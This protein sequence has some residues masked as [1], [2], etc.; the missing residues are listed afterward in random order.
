MVDENNRDSQIAGVHLT[1]PDR[2]LYPRQGITKRELALYYQGI[3]DWILPHLQGR[4][5][6]LV[7]CPEGQEKECFYQ[8]H[9]SGSIHESVRRVELREEKGMATYLMADSLSG[10]IALVQMGV[11]ELHTWGSRTDKLE[12]P[13]RLVFDLDPGPGIPWTAVVEAAHAM[14]DRLGALGLN[15]LVKTTG[16]KGLH[17]VAPLTRRHDWDDIKG[18]SKAI[19]ES[20]VQEA[21]KRYTATM[22]KAKRKGKIFID[23]LRNQRGA[24]TVAAYSSRAAPDA[25]ISAPIGWDELDAS[26]G[27]SQYNI[28]NLPRRLATLRRD[29]WQ[30][31]EAAR[32][33]ILAKTKKELARML[34][35]LAT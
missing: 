20:F 29:P 13:D 6:T 9:A 31:Y 18:F 15:A 34:A 16:G 25:P 1:H 35:S 8:K 10:L 30:G 4:P 17:V 24:T 23:Y 14:R 26:L 12:R 5:L 21:P 28:R 7:R 22:S 19:A 33:S 27:P 11:L 32:A 3:A 2:I